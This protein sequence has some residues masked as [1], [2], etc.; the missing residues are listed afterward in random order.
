[1]I[2][3]LC[4]GVDLME[5]YKSP[6][7]SAREPLLSVAC[8]LFTFN[9]K[10]LNLRFPQHVI[11]YPNILPYISYPPHY[12]YIGP[13]PQVMNID[14]IHAIHTN[15][16]QLGKA[17]SIYRPSW[18]SWHHGKAVVAQQTVH[19]QQLHQGEVADES[20]GLVL[21]SQRTHHD[22]LDP[23]LILVETQLG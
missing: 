8:N 21:G 2:P 17:L 1:M 6:Y 5:L 12:N 23:C 15:L 19:S 7:F 4:W 3:Q 13:I 16:K 11:P 10:Q 22:R 14:P 20:C 9:K 18:M